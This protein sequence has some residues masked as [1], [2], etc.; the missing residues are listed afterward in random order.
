[1]QKPIHI[2]ATNLPDAWHQ[3]VYA[4]LDH[5]RDFIIDAGSNAGQTRKE[6]DFFTCHI[7]YPGAVPMLPHLNPA[8]GIPDPV[9]EGY[10]TQY[11]PYLMTGAEK[12]GEAY[13]YGQRINQADIVSAF[14]GRDGALDLMIPEMSGEKPH[15]WLTTDGVRHF[16]SQVDLA[17]YTYKTHGHRTNQMCLQVAQPTD[18]LLK[19]PPCLRHIDTRIQD[20]KLHFYP[21]FRSWDLWGG[22]PA[23]LAAIELLK[24]YMAAEIGAESGDILAVS[25]GLHLYDYVFEI[26][27][28][29]RG[30]KF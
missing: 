12:K 9:A 10:L 22:F 5:G 20:G 4:A 17:I 19:D 30:G 24:Q 29:I 21:Y 14:S 13:T 25:K 26:A 28:A 3:A 2:K 27:Q 6:L 8:A 7:T 23:N 11:L 18:M 16:V 1:M 15:N